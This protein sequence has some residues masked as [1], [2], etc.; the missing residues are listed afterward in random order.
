MKSFGFTDVEKWIEPQPWPA[1]AV[2]VPRFQAHRGCW[3]ASIK[4]NSRES[5]VEAK[6]NH[7]FMCEVDVRLSKDSEVVLCHDEDLSRV[8]G[9]SQK[10]FEL[11]YADLKKIGLV[12][13]KE[14]LLDENCC[15]RLNIELKSKQVLQDK[16]ERMVAKV[17]QET[18]SEKRIY[19]SSFNPFS[20]WR[21]AQFLPQVPRALLV[22]DEDVPGNS[23]FLKKKWLA[24]FLS[25]HALH[26]KETMINEVDLKKY[27][28]Q[29]IPIALWT[30]NDTERALK[31][32]EW[33]AW[34]VITD[35]VP[36]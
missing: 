10:V 33:G 11:N 16:L 5:L 32:F 29:R 26:L 17:V 14:A 36:K 21:I 30:V 8:W 27:N 18:Q 12:S 35:H 3:N 9:V 2:Q 1:T 24:P 4:E 28:R 34:S 7:I 15:Y 22:S 23:L 20:L 6:R 31:F 25:I 19:F 13:L